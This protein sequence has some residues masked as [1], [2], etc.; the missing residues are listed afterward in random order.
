MKW[1]IIVLII[2]G[3][4]AAMC[5]SLLVAALSANSRGVAVATTMTVVIAARDLPARSVVTDE[6]LVT[7]EFRRDKVPAESLTG[8]I[9]AIGKIL[10]VPIVKGQ[11]LNDKC[12]V[13]DAEGVKLASTL[14]RGQRA[15]SVALTS[16]G[17][18][19][20]L[21][22]RGAIV[23][24]LATFQASNDEAG[25]GELTS[26]TLLQGIPVLSIGGKASSKGRSS[27]GRG[28]IVTLLLS[29]VQAES[30]RLATERG[31]I[32]LAMRNPHD[33]ATVNHSPAGTPGGAPK[34]VNPDEP[35]WETVVIRGEVVQTRYLPMPE[36]KTAA[37]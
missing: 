23:D 37:K 29:S 4:A 9:Q 26:K 27:G 20:G 28:R 35:H 34:R 11:A 30:L 1:T 15:V 12:F 16:Y 8:K 36:N 6:D 2:A 10:L 19:S 5:A 14:G 18:L 13:G 32:S 33:V 21:L 24:V 17:G 22:Y 7:E 3:L 31:T 25:R